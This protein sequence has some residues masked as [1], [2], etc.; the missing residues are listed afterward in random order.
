[1]MWSTKLSAFL[2]LF[3]A[4]VESAEPSASKLSQGKGLERRGES[5]ATGTAVPDGGVSGTKP[6]ECAKA[7]GG[8]NSPYQIVVSFM[9]CC[10]NGTC[11]KE[12]EEALLADYNESVQR[13][14][15][16]E[17]RAALIAALKR[18]AKWTDD[19]RDKFG[20]FTLFKGVIANFFIQQRQDLHF[21]DRANWLIE[22]WERSFSA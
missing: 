17:D 20:N 1:M 6:E 15:T 22:I 9:E 16:E 3:A 11:T 13:L 18:L 21:N 12:D 19:N 2:V 5:T 14:L 4:V 7:T 8:T 10:R